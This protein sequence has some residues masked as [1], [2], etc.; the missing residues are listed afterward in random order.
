[1]GAQEYCK[2]KRRKGVVLNPEPSK[3]ELTTEVWS[4]F[5]STLV[6]IGAAQCGNSGIIS[7]KSKRKTDAIYDPVH[8]LEENPG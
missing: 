1:M 3:Y 4:K 7:S 8:V 6:V 5:G 2:W